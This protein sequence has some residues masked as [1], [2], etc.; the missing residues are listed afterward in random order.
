M[1]DFKTLQK[2]LPRIYSFLPFYLA[3]RFSLLSIIEP[4]QHVIEV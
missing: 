3:P 1:M 4:Y 2:I